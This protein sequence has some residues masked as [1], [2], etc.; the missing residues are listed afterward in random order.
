MTLVAGIWVKELT[1]SARL[2]GLA[3]ACLYTASLLAP[4][5]GLL[6]DRVPRR[7]LLIWTNRVAASGLLLLLLVD[8]RAEVW[9]I[10]IVLL[11]YGLVLVVLDPAETALFTEIV[12]VEERG[13]LNGL[14]LSLQEGAKLAAPLLGAGLFVVAGAHGV[15]A[16]DAATFAVAAVVAARIRSRPGPPPRPPASWPVELAAG[17]H[18]LRTTPRL[19]RVVVTAAAAMAVSGLTVAARYDLVDA[20]HRPPAFLGVLTAVLGAGSIVG[21]LTGGRLLRR[22]REPR[23]LAGALANGCGGYLLVA[24]GWLPAVLAG[25]AV[26][27]LFL[28]WAVIATISMGQ[29][30]SPDHL[31]G[32]VASAITLLLFAPLPGTSAAGAVLLGALT[33]R[34][35]YVLS[36]ALIAVVLMAFLSLG[37]GRHARPEGPPS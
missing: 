26:F 13:A 25:F 11:G 33:Y 15:V 6:A 14:R 24:S 36:V 20:L 37:P 2:A 35:M 21:G 10:F 32:R 19:G 23:L 5:A 1:G 18:H 4:L 17:L 7:T 16:L 29:R 30:W 27:G 12:P 9:L 8:S 3:N 28:P 31:Q 34:G 22:I